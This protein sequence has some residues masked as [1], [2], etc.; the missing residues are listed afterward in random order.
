MAKFCG[1]CG[2]KLDEATGLCPNCDAARIEASSIQKKPPE[3]T[4]QKQETVQEA[5]KPLSKKEEKQK[6]KADKKAAKKARKKEKRAQMT[7]GQKIKTFFVKVVITLFC[8]TI[9]VGVGASVLVYFDIV[10]I[11][12]IDTIMDETGIK[13]VTG[14]NSGYVQIGGK[15]TSVK[16]TDSDSAIAAAQ[17]AAENSGL[18]SAGNELSVININTIDGVT[19]YRLQQNYKG[20]PVYGRTFI[21]SADDLGN[22]QS[23]VTNGINI[24]NV[25]TSKSIHLEEAKAIIKNYL[26]K[27]YKSGSISVFNNYTEIIYT[28]SDDKSIFAYKF[29][30]MVD[31]DLYEVFLGIEEKV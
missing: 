25:D 3:R 11:P 16:V 27:T 28:F 22:T 19:Y 4:E 15:F 21:V 1:K 2:T 9:L 24:D 7:F 17:E 13:I 5:E 26:D 29:N 6:R 31:N 20:I 30:A 12:L 14:S 23:L 8:L 18:G 10:D